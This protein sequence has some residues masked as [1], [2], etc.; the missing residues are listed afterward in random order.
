MHGLIRTLIPT[1][2]ICLTAASCKSN[3][4]G[5]DETTLS[6]GTDGTESGETGE[7]LGEIC[8]GETFDFG[9]DFL[10]GD[11]EGTC[12]VNSTEELEPLLGVTCIPGILVVDQTAIDPIDSLQGLESVTE[13]GRL[14][15]RYAPALSSVDGLNNVTRMGSLLVFGTMALTDVRHFE[16]LTHVDNSIEFTDN[17]ALT[18][19][20]GLEGITDGPRFD[21]SGNT[22]LENFSGLSQLKTSRKIE[23]IGNPAITDMSGFD[24][25][26][27]IDGELKIEENDAL[28]TLD[29]FLILQE[30]TSNIFILSNHMLPTCIAQMFSEMVPEKG[31]A[32]V[33]SDNSVDTCGEKC[34]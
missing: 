17:E 8:D 11:P 3:T 28:A 34:D 32:T 29:G 21:I 12:V 9:P 18:A 31:G 30:V 5:T 33:C 15:L 13:I 7:E 27:V 25:L 24:S 19:L 26:E 1:V 14:E 22:L 10:C 6:A 4:Q 20:T 16:S 23:I 2:A